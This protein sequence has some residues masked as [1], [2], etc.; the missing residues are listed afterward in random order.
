MIK[1]DAFG[2]EMWRY[3]GRILKR[4]QYCIVLE[5][6]FDRQDM[7][8]NGMPLRQGDRF[9]E[10][11]FTNRWYNIFEI[12]DGKDDSLRGW[13]IN[14][15]HP[16]MIQSGSISY[17]DLALDVLIFPDGSEVVLDKEEFE[18]LDLLLEIKAK[19]LEGLAQIKT[20]RFY[21]DLL[22]NRW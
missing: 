21:Q 16:A 20:D 17:K 5:A 10:T 19:A 1:Q 2:K 12:H 13:Y 4:E 15:S 14:I 22:R 11:Y 8:V 7:M 9:I 6:Y 3:D 18:A